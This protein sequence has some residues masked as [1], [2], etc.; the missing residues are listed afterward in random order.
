MISYSVRECLLI[1]VDSLIAPIPT[2]PCVLLGPVVVH[3]SLHSSRKS[4]CRSGGRPLPSQDRNETMEYSTLFFLRNSL[5]VLTTFGR[6]KGF[7]REGF[8]W[9]SRSNLC[10][11]PLWVF[12]SL[13]SRTR[14]NKAKARSSSSGAPSRQLIDAI[15][16]MPLRI[17]D[18]WLVEDGQS[19]MASRA[20]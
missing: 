16:H 17:V 10:V 1:V 12:V 19:E 18:E 3:Y 7:P 4:P 5:L 2:I 11:F 13:L 9:F 6:N 8:S 14:F 20:F 15:V